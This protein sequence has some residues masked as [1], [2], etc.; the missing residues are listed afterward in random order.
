STFRKFEGTVAGHLLYLYPFS[1]PRFIFAF[2]DATSGGTV[3]FRNASSSFTVPRYALSD[4]RRGK[5]HHIAVSYD[6]EKG[7]G[8]IWVDGEKVYDRTQGNMILSTPYTASN[9]ALRPYPWGTQTVD[10]GKTVL[11]P[12][13]CQFES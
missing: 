10:I 3:E 13:A 2:Y 11:W 9:L 5:W 7:N 1:S 12:Y 4:V 6:A 8:K